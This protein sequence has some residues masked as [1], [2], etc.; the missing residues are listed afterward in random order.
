MLRL[1]RFLRR[2][3]GYE[4]VQISAMAAE[5]GVRETYRVKGRYVMTH[6]DYVEARWRTCRCARCRSPDATAS[7]WRDGA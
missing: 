5:T 4:G 7:G 2:Q 3:P 6:A 1:Y